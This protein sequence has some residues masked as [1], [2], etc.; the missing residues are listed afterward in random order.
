M[1]PHVSRSLAAVLLSAAL[2][3]ACTTGTPTPPAPTPLAPTLPGMPS[4]TPSLAPTPTVVISEDPAALRGVTLQA[5]NAFTGTSEQVFASQ[6]AQFNASNQWGIVVNPVG[7]GDY[8]SLFEVVNGAIANASTSGGTPDLVAA[9]P[10]QTLTWESA[11][12]VVDLTPYTNHPVWGLGE[13]GLAGIPAVFRAQD[14]LPDGRLLGLPAERSARFL[15]YNQTWA[16]ELGFDSPPATADEFRQQ[17]CA[18]NASF[19][20]NASPQDDGYGGWIVDPSWQTT[21]AW[22][23][24]FGGSVED[25]GA[26]TFST[27]PNLAALQFM[28]G[29]YD[30]NC[31]WISLEPR[32]FDS[33]AARSALFVSGDLAEVATQA[34]SMSRLNN[35]DQWTVIPYP[36]PDGRVMVTYGPSFSLLRS[37]PER[38]LAAWLFLR[39]LLSP[40]NQSQWVAASGLLPLL[41]FVQNPSASPQWQAA[42]G[43]LS[44][45]QGVPQLASWR[46]VRYVLED[47]TNVIFQTGIAIDKLPSILIEMDATAKEISDQ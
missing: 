36:G 31:A 16:R 42:V 12:L 4:P 20:Q 35:S 6:V 27:D 41:D 45:A 25:G 15:F 10:E 39:W 44:L 5:W 43:E 21:Y 17:A 32:P 46:K 40:E 22:M 7:Y 24:T 8:T 9:L 33:F 18:A 38:H 1:N 3:C 26:Y 13:A 29:L 19:R 2:L 34:E 47:G 23:L 14:T 37:T 28:K 30:D 11:G